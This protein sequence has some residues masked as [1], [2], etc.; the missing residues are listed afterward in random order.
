MFG[1]SVC[2]ASSVVSSQLVFIF[3]PKIADK[4]GQWQILFCI[5]AAGK[6]PLGRVL[7]ADME[8]DEADEAVE[9]RALIHGIRVDTHAGESYLSM[10]W[11]KHQIRYSLSFN[12][13]LPPLPS[14][15]PFFS[16]FRP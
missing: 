12:P 6:L 2:T 16:P 1:S 10:S 11:L 8:G 5:T 15:R 14:P 9:T 7:S 13:P 3:Y 4:T